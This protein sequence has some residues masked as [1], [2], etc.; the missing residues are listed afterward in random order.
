MICCLRNIWMDPMGDQG[1]TGFNFYRVPS[2]KM[3]FLL[4][5]VPSTAYLT[6]QKKWKKSKPS[7]CLVCLIYAVIYATRKEFEKQILMNDMMNK[8]Q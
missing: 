6:N 7:I 5:R 4:V 8:K 2:I 3:V 1:C